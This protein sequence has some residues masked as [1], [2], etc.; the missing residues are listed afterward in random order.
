MIG[1]PEELIIRRACILDPATGIDGVNDVRLRGGRIV[2]V[3]DGLRGLR[4]LDA[5]GLHLFPGFV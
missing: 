1:R 4:E 5:D 3:G 2:E